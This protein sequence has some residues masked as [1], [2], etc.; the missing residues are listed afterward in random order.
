MEIKR[1]FVVQKLTGKEWRDYGK[2]ETEGEAKEHHYAVRLY[3]Q[4]DDIFRVIY[5]ETTVCE[6]E[7]AIPTA[8]LL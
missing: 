4:C 7:R 2:F 6:T 5:R 3:G 8:P 1:S